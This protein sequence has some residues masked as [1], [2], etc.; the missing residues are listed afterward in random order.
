MQVIVIGAGIWGLACAY[1]CAR[2]GDA[3]TVYDAGRVGDGASGGIVGA[4]A[5]HVPDQWNPKKQFQFEALDTADLFWS[6]A[7]ALSG[8]PSGYGRIGRLQPLLSKKAM[9]LAEARST[10]AKD[11]WQGLYHWQIEPCP[12][13]M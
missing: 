8:I 7:D 2:R 13:T 9:E 3:V 6:K 10:S 1:A 11:L 12:D 5:P 4:L